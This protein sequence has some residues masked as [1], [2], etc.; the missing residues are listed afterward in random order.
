MPKKIVVYETEDGEEFKTEKEALAWEAHLEEIE[1]IDSILK[2][3]YNVRHW[4]NAS[5]EHG[6]ILCATYLEHSQEDIDKFYKALLDFIMKDA[7]YSLKKDLAYYVSN[8]GKKMIPT[9][10]L[11]YL[12]D[13]HQAASE[14]R[15]L[16][17]RATAINLK[18]RRE[19]DSIAT[20]EEIEK[21]PGHLKE[22]IEVPNHEEY[23]DEE[24]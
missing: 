18:T 2:S 23:E 20:K 10:N 24:Y 8:F 1:R 13:R 15:E 7:T 14:T 5:P 12:C 11:L 21:L 17:N 6:K 4:Y 19:Y 16:L 9:Y 22:E 3:N